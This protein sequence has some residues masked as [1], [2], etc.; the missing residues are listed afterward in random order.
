LC[1]VAI[2]IVEPARNTGSSTAYGVAAP[3]RPMLT[4]ILSSLVVA[5]C[6]G[7]LNAVAHRGNFAVVP[8]R[9]RSARSSTFTTTPSVSNSS[10]CR[11]SAHSA[12]K[13]ATSSMFAHDRQ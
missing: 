6:A 3:V 2:E 10:V 7:N 11:L 1:S 9:S 12:Q 4:S 13:A 5:C 8:R